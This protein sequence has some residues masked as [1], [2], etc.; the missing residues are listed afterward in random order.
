MI[1]LPD[2]FLR[3]VRISFGTEGERCLA[4]LPKLLN[5]AARHW[6]TDNST[7]LTA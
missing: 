6:V 5:K 2:P 4:E 3:N 7:S 1:S